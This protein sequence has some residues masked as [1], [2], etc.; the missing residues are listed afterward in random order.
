MALPQPENASLQEEEID[1]ELP[2]RIFIRTNKFEQDVSKDESVI[3]HSHM[4]TEIDRENK[5]D[6]KSLMNEIVKEVINKEL[7]SKN[8]KGQIIKKFVWRNLNK[9]HMNIFLELVSECIVLEH[10][11][12]PIETIIEKNNLAFDTGNY[13]LTIWPGN[14]KNKTLSYPKDETRIF[15]KKNKKQYEATASKIESDFPD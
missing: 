12:L 6:R 14:K 13:N 8:I 10:Y 2:D 1:L 4:F 7:L 9:E 15:L 3:K 11:T 5:V